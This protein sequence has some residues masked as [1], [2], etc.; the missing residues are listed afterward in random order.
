MIE[1]AEFLEALRTCR[2]RTQ[3][4]LT[5]ARGPE[6]PPVDEVPSTA[7]ESLEAAVAELDAAIYEINEDPDIEI[8]EHLELQEFVD[9]PRGR[10]ME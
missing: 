1:T 9:M 7:L 2:E 10:P 3:A 4:L 8:I 5:L 6:H